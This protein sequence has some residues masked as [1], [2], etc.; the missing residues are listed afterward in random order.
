MSRHKKIEMI[1][2]CGCLYEARAPDLKRGWG[3]SCSKSC[4]SIRRKYGKPKGKP[5]NESKKVNK[6]KPKPSSLR[7]NDKR[8]YNDGYNPDDDYD[9]SWDAH[10][11]Y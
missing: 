11:D 2:H 8:T 5:V 6:T 3:L 7:P 10:K 9:P 1:C 4:A